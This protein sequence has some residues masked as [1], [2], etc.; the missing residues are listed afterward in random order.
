M[1]KYSKQWDEYTKN[2]PELKNI[3][4]PLFDLPGYKEEIDIERKS[5]I[6]N[7][8]LEK[9]LKETVTKLRTISL[10]PNEDII[11]IFMNALWDANS[12]EPKNKSS[13]E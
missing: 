8:D 5:R 6:I 9:R 11:D 1:E 2:T 12:S 4:K 13:T 10:Y 3:S 7:L